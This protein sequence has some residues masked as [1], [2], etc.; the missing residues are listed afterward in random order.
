MI[1][2]MITETIILISF[3]D[4]FVLFVMGGDLSTSDVPNIEF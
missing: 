4:P 3:S 2:V 1:E